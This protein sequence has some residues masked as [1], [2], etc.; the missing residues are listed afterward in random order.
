M[1]ERIEALIG[2]LRSLHGLDW[3]IL[4]VSAKKDIAECEEMF[5]HDEVDDGKK[6]A[7]AQRCRDLTRDRV[8][9]EIA[10]DETMAS[11]WRIVLKAIDDPAP[12]PA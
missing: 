8:L 2:D 5:R 12:A 6:D 10:R 3:Y 9:E 1:D 7:A 4:K 11:H